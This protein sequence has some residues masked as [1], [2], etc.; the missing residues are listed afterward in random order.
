MPTDF[1][2]HQSSGDWSNPSRYWVDASSFFSGSFV[3]HN[4][5]DGNSATRWASATLPASLTVGVGAKQLLDNYTIHLN[6][7]PTQAP[8]TFEMQGS[9]D[10]VTW[11][12]LDT[13][14]SETGWS[15]P[16][17]RNYTVTGNTTP[18]WLYRLSVT[19]VDGSSIVSIH[20][21]YLYAVTINT[22]DDVAPHSMTGFSAPSPYVITESG[23]VSSFNAWEAFNDPGGSTFNSWVS[24]APSWVVVD[25]GSGNA[26][27]IRGY[28]LFN[29][30]ASDSPTEWA[31]EGSNDG[32]SWTSIDSKTGQTWSNNGETSSIANLYALAS[33]TAAYRYYRLTITAGAATNIWLRELH[34]IPAATS[35]GGGGGVVIPVIVHHLRQQ[36]I[37]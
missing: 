22:V 9:N 33:D 32:S 34:L 19:A 16:E 6:S 1:A 11:T 18:Y 13:R 31:L 29:V 7:D 12:T 8:K 37:M 24:N 26:K 17:A 21:L 35:A 15:V 28:M 20:E 2:P 27:A 30:N 5:F 4:A 3:A 25:L 14:S 36:G 10:G 23:H